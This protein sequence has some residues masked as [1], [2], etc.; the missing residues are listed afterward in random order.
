MIQKEKLIHKQQ[1]LPPFDVVQEVYH[2]VRET[3]F[4]DYA[5]DSTI[6]RN[7]QENRNESSGL[8]GGTI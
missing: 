5:E 4:D 7:L 2:G 1:T 6:A 3:L 8:L